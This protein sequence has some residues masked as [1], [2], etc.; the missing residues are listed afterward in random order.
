MS[1]Y[2]S[3]ISKYFCKDECNCKDIRDLSLAIEREIFVEVYRR[4]KE[5][6]TRGKMKDF[7]S[8]CESF[9]IRVLEN[10]MERHRYELENY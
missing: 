9:C 6:I 5:I 2:K 3:P 10:N 1:F 8:A 4:I 7:N